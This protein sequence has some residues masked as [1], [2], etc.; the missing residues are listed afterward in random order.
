MPICQSVASFSAYFIRR[1]E[2]KTDWI[3]RNSCS[4]KKKAASHQRSLLFAM[5]IFKQNAFIS[6]ITASDFFPPFF[7]NHATCLSLQLCVLR[8]PTALGDGEMWLGSDSVRCCSGTLEELLCLIP[9]N[10]HLGDRELHISSFSLP[11][12]CLLCFLEFFFYFIYFFLTLAV[13]CDKGASC[14]YLPKLHG[15]VC[16]VHVAA[17]S[18]AVTESTL[19]WDKHATLGVTGSSVFATGALCFPHMDLHIPGNWEKKKNIS[20]QTGKLTEAHNHVMLLC[21]IIILNSCISN[22][23]Q[24]LCVTV[25]CHRHA[26]EKKTR[27]A[28]SDLAPRT[29]FHGSAP[30][31]HEERANTH[32]KRWSIIKQEILERELVNPC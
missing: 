26:Y 24:C 6:A 2:K 9:Q 23:D 8:T 3:S 10:L 4:G 12:L 32:V 30:R 16:A 15:C 31:Q 25:F 14:P 28:K 19:C 18:D 7:A 27:E 17:A 11:S 13:W 22:E 5:S 29:S 20:P 21:N 1:E